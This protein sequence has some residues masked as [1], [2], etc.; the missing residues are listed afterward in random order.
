MMARE[1]WWIPAPAGNHG[2]MACSRAERA[3]NRPARSLAIAMAVPLLAAC[4]SPHAAREHPAAGD[5]LRVKTAGIGRAGLRLLALGQ[6]LVGAIERARI[7]LGQA[8]RLAAVLRRCRRNQGCIYS[9]R[10]CNKACCRDDSS[11]GIY[12]FFCFV[13][14]RGAQLRPRAIVPARKRIS[15]PQFCMPSRRCVA[16]IIRCVASQRTTTKLPCECERMSAGA[17]RIGGELAARPGSQLCVKAC[18]KI[19][20]CYSR[21]N[22]RRVFV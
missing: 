14:P 9:N 11:H 4:G 5:D 18:V 22:T 10:D 13:G 12:P 15:T 2:Q 7:R 19:A 21:V 17:G 8:V 16:M 6:R 1:L 3:G 20:R